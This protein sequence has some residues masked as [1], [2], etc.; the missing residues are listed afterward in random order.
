MSYEEQI[1][2]INAQLAQARKDLATHTSQRVA[3]EIRTADWL[4]HVR[5]MGPSADSDRALAECGAAQAQIEQ[6]IKDD[7]AAIATLTA[8]LDAATK[9]K[10]ASDAALATAASKGLTGDVAL[11][12]AKNETIMIAIGVG[13]IAV[14]VGFWAWRKFIRKK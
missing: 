11:Q 12:K 1:A 5:R 8:Q 7:N 2:S 9:A 13:L 3:N 10:A 4:D 6:Q 14:V